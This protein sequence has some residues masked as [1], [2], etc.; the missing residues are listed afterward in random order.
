MM[1]EW[2]ASQVHRKQPPEAAADF[3]ATIDRIF[4]TMMNRSIL[5][6]AL[7]RW[8]GIRS[9]NYGGFR[10]D[11]VHATPDMN[12][13]RIW[14][15]AAVGT[16]SGLEFYGRL[17]NICTYYGPDPTDPTRI[18][19]TGA[20]RFVPDGFLAM[21]LDLNRARALRRTD[22][23]DHHSWI[24]TPDWR[25][26]GI[27]TS[28][29]EKSPY[30]IENVFQQAIAGTSLI[31]FWNPMREESAT[32]EELEARA[33]HAGAL[34]DAL[35]ELDRR[36]RGACPLDP[37]DSSRLDWTSDW[38]LGGAELPDGSRLWRVTTAPGVRSV[39]VKIGGAPTSIGIDDEPGAWIISGRGQAVEVTGVSRD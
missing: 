39:Q 16:H 9:S 19:R 11:P 3:N 33:R 36:T 7:A 22:D 14:G 31:L 1:G 35:A 10:V 38:V 29:Y 37:I 27:S 21:K 24:A 6:P 18:A 32:P 5:G 28:Y 23:R 25:S 12:A 15:N 2:T 8:P 4:A 34:E 20:G 13:S 30:W 17:R 26:D